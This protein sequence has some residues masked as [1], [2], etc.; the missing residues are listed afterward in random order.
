MS[1]RDLLVDGVVLGQEDAEALSTPARLP[2]F[3]FDRR[4]GD[5]GCNGP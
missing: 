4:G 5:R 2:R 3:R 1:D